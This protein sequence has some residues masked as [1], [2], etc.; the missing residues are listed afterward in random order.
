MTQIYHY[1]PPQNPEK[2]IGFVSVPHSGEMLPPDMEKF[3]NEDV[4]ARQEDLDYKVNELIHIQKLNEKG[5]HVLVANIHRTAVDLNREDIFSILYWKKNT[6]GLPL[7]TQEPTEDE[8]KEFIEKYYRPYYQKLDEVIEKLQSQ[9]KGYCPPVIDLHSMPSKPSTYHLQKNPQ[10]DTKRPDFCLSDQFGKSC[11]KEY[12]EYL[13]QFFLQKKYETTIN[14]PYV[15]GHVTIYL[16]PKFINNIQ[17]E[18]N[19]SLYM[20]ETQKELIPEKVDP[21]K[22]DITEGLLELFHNFQVVKD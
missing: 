7:Y 3:F 13:Q 22:N 1:Y 5:V 8:K 14:K 16:T 18:I 19:R 20:D 12:I 10:Q 6:K 2:A 9:K 15:G 11:S 17:V 21:L 4:R